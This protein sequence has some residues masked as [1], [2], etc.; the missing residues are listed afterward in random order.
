MVRFATGHRRDGLQ[1]LPS[2]SPGLPRGSMGGEK[3]DVPVEGC[4]QGDTPYLRGQLFLRRRG[5]SASGS[6]GRLHPSSNAPILVACCK[7]PAFQQ[8]PPPGSEN[9]GYREG[10]RGPLRQSSLPPPS[11][12]WCRSN[13]TPPPVRPPSPR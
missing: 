3:R 6:E 8:V 11:G 1:G 13:A 10:L 9:P 7:F 12:A 5:R 4:R 2:W